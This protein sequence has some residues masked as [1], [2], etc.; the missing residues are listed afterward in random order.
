MSR[1]KSGGGRGR[2]GREREEGEGRRGEGRKER[3]GEGEEGEGRARGRKRRG[4]GGEGTG[5]EEE[6]GEGR[7]T[8]DRNHHGDVASL[9]VYLTSS[10]DSSSSHH[11]IIGHS[12]SR[13]HPP[14]PPTF[15]LE[16]TSSVFMSHVLTT[17]KCFLPLTVSALR[18][19][20]TSMHVTCSKS[21]NLTLDVTGD[22]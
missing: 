19:D 20:T 13:P 8:I 17:T 6:G 18:S 1:R 22:R 3:E 16:E 5:R 21:S 9:S 14:S 7:Q 2:E 11:C 15:P 12:M 4:L 10:C